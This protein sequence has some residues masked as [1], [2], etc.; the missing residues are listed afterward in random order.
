MNVLVLKTGHRSLEYS[1]FFGGPPQAQLAGRVDDYRGTDQS[2]SALSKMCGRI[3]LVRRRAEDGRDVDAIGVC[4]QFGGAEFRRPTPVSADVLEKIEKLVPHAPLHLPAVLTLIRCC[5][6]VFPGTP[7]VLAFQTAFFAGLASR[8]RLYAL[9]N[10]LTKSL[11]LRR[12][13]FHGILHEAACHHVARLRRKRGIRAAARV[14]SLCLGPRP[15]L[16]AVIGSRPLMV[17]SGATP[18]EGIPGET[19]CGELDP[20]VVLTLREK[21]EW[22]PEKINM[23]LTQES[24]LLGLVGEP[25]TIQTLFESDNPDVKEAREIVQY[26]ILQAC[27]AGIAAMGGLDAIVF[28]GRYAAVGELHGPW[29]ASRLVPRNQQGI[30]FERFEESLERIVADVA[31][32]AALAKDEQ[33]A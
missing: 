14:L 3:Q 9:E 29:L 26:R 11:G 25:T 28:S 13:G 24:G 7:V 22:G 8:E 32:A 21:M 20:S 6:D 27:G 4:V 17:T 10:G 18:L 30:S 12:Y 23:V 1:Y 2:R 16:A 33:A 19:V 31:S 15:E 5:K